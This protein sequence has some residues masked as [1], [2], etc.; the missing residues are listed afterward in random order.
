MLLHYLSIGF[1]MLNVINSAFNVTFTQIL[2]LMHH[3][4][5]GVIGISWGLGISFMLTTTISVLQLREILHPDYLS[6]IIK[7]QEIHSDILNALC[8]ESIPSQFRRLV[9]SFTVYV[10]LV[11]LFV[12]IPLSIYINIFIHTLK[13]EYFTFYFWNFAPELL[14]PLEMGMAHIIFLVV[15]EQHKNKIGYAQYAWLHFMCHK[16]HISR[17]LLPFSYKQMV[18]VVQCT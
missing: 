12:Y 1:L 15:L 3:N 6:K 11:I 2:L 17:Y 16:L 18:S 5:L 13:F 14:L 4:I 7:P 8:K 9:I 10:I